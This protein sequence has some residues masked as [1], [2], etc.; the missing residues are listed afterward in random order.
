MSRLLRPMLLAPDI[1]EAVLE[2]RQPEAMRLEDLLQRFPM[3]WEQRND[4]HQLIP[5]PGS[6]SSFARSAD[7]LCNYRNGGH[8]DLSE[9]HGRENLR[10]T[11]D[12][13]PV[14]PTAARLAAPTS[15]TPRLR[16][17]PRSSRQWRPRAADGHPLEAPMTAADFSQ[18]LPIAI[19]ILFLLSPLAV[20]FMIFALR[21]QRRRAQGEIA[22]LEGRLRVAAAD[23]AA[24]ESRYATIIDAEAEAARISVEAAEVK[25]SVEGLAG[26]TPP[27]AAYTTRLA[28]EVAVFDERIAFAELGV[29]EPHFDFTDS[30][31]Y[32]EKVREARDRQKA[33]VSAKTAAVCPKDWQVDG[34]APRED[35]DQPSHPAG[36]ARLQQRMRGDHRQCALEQCC[37]VRDADRSVRRADRQWT[38]RRRAHQ[39]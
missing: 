28:A 30:E 7:C 4:G 25:N 39:Q 27:S 1:V 9:P 6:I 12:R 8:L 20:I 38:N 29:Y 16:S 21:R 5:Q 26:T 3:E 24:I 11:N 35:D 36:L 10:A 32:K 33:M 14:V 22:A 17:G 37:R 34:S 13:P 31:T 15:V 23:K 19:A 2:G 18:Y